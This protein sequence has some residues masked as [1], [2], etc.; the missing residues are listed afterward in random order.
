[1]KKKLVSVILI[2]AMM[3]LLLPAA[4]MAEREI[5][6][7]VSKEY[8]FNSF[9]GT[10]IETVS[11]ANLEV[12]EKIV[13]RQNGV[14]VGEETTDGEYIYESI[15]GK[16]ILTAEIVTPTDEIVCVSAPV[17]I[18]FIGCEQL[19]GKKYEL[20]FDSGEFNPS[21]FLDFTYFNKG[22]IP[23]VVFDS[24]KNSYVMKVSITGSQYQGFEMKFPGSSIAG[25]FN[26]GWSVYEFD[27]KF[28][29]FGITTNRLY[30]IKTAGG[31]EMVG[32]SVDSGKMS[33]GYGGE[34]L[35]ADEWYHIKSV[36]NLDEKTEDF[37]INGVKVVS[38]KALKDNFSDI[39]F[40][41]L[42]RFMNFSDTK[43]STY[44]IDNISLANYAKNYSVTSY[45][46]INGERTEGLNGFPLS[47]GSAVLVFSEKMEKMDKSS[48]EFTVDGRSTD[49]DFEYDSND[50]AARITPKNTLSGREQCRISFDNVKTSLGLGSSGD[51]FVDFSADSPVY[52]I[53]SVNHT[54]I[55]GGELCDFNI[56]LNNS[57]A[58]VKNGLVLVGLYDET[59]LLSVN[60]ANVMVDAMSKGKVSLKLNIPS[61]YNPKMHK[62][63]TYLITDNTYFAIDLLS[64]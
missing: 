63:L 55:V 21:D 27:I 35:N 1:M 44:C 57:S 31:G 46:E 33:A 6:L 32:A 17:E 56:E 5:I 45:K 64:E 26:G 52:G 7:S 62:I 47:G 30:F 51:T 20:T 49:F 11:T 36:I 14:V 61:E 4:V 13:Y 16:N 18:E 54:D 38:D 48:F 29:N 53:A 25:S 19:P 43:D 15:A 58:E 60:T 37:Y 24:E 10:K 8:D 22:Y 12:G 50:N 41:S 42:P 9:P 28:N 34:N 3:V 40:Y 59:G 39:M 2:A 23:E